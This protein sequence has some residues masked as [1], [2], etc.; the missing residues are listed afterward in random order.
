M[1]TALIDYTKRAGNSPVPS[2]YVEPKLEVPS[3]SETFAINLQATVRTFYTDC[4]E[5]QPY[6]NSQYQYPIASF[7]ADNGD[8]LDNKAAG[9]W[10]YLKGALASGKVRV[11]EA[12]VVYKPGQIG[13]T[14]QRIKQLFGAQV[15][16]N[17]LVVKIDMESGSDFAGPGDHSPEANQ[18]AADLAAYLGS[19]QRVVGYGNKYD[20]QACWPGI[21]ARI[22]KATAA[23][24]TEDPGTYSW[25]YYGGLNYSTL[26]GFPREAAPFG[27]WVDLNVI[28]RSISQIETDYGIVAPPAKDWFDMATAA[29]L[30]KAVSAGTTNVNEHIKAWGAVRF[31]RFPSAKKNPTA[32]YVWDGSSLLW[33][34]PADWKALGTPNTGVWNLPTTGNIY[35]CPIVSGTP[36]PRK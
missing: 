17:R 29:D 22:K 27:G 26:A 33:L 15:P 31:V 20:F 3:I 16:T 7:R 34:T 35:K 10:S 11:A 24:G 5:F 30:A 28:S 21:D 19:W 36:D 32:I 23:Y 2:S 13:A 14:M 25:Q 8:R 9:N 12:Y 1:T 18:L 6:Y 4:S